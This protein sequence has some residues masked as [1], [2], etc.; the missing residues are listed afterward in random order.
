MKSILTIILCFLG[1][2]ASAQVN[3]EDKLNFE[4]EY[5]FGG[6]IY[7]K[8]I[9]LDF[10]FTKFKSIRKAIFFHTE[11]TNIRNPK[12]I[13]LSNPI[14][15]QT[16][17]YTF[18]KMNQAFALHLG[19]GYRYYL[20]PKLANSDAAVSLNVSGGLSFAFLKPVYL[21]VYEI[22]AKDP[23]GR[24][25]SYKVTE[26][27]AQP[28]YDIIGNSEFSKGLNELSTRVG[29]YTKVGLNVDWSDY[30]ENV[31]SIEV[32]FII[33]AF[34]SP[35]PLLRKYNNNNIYST[36]YIAFCIGNKY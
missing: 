30:L 22:D 20:A 31:K 11:I 10:K 24:I 29:L 3:Y 21:N 28:Q 13:K 17:I 9:G 25:V 19:M 5:T 32:G 23:N 7:N 34:A 12:E 16:G 6:Q 27:N 35:L 18:N 36:F 1:T 8:G 2:L 15:D 14:Q 33:N 4:N 26:E